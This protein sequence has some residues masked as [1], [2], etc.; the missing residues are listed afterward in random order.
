MKGATAVTEGAPLTG[1][2]H[3]TIGPF[4]AETLPAGL[5]AEHRL[6]AGTWG[7]V[8]LLEGSLS[9]AWDDGTGRTDRVTAPAEVIV[10]PQVPHHVQGAGP[11][12]LTIA[13]FRESE[14]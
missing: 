10:P 8:R 3:R 12:T 1:A 6:K 14:A 9:F 2:P 7:V 4:D 5:R 11:F 13:F